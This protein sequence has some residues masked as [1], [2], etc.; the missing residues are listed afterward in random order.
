MPDLFCEPSFYIFTMLIVSMLAQVISSA[1]FF[2]FMKMG[3]PSLLVS[4]YS[5]A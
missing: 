2:A 3:V 4:Y 5:S 1:V